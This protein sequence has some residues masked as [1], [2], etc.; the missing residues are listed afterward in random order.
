VV[1]AAALLRNGKGHLTTMDINPDSGFLI[2]GRYADVTQIARGDSVE[3]ISILTEP[4]D[5]FIH[6]SDHSAAHEASEY[7]AVASHLAPSALVLS[8][9]SHI[10]SELPDWA[11]STGRTFTFFR[12]EP[13]DHWY[14][15]AGIGAAW[16]PRG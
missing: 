10:T 5:L 8:D 3:L 16:Y 7:A 4:I 6:D 14:Q 13:E 1:I 11:E 2:S 12:E 9:N 15:G